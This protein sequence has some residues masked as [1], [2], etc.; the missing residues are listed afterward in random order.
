[1]LTN[2]NELLINSKLGLVENQQATNMNPGVFNFVGSS[3]KPKD[4]SEGTI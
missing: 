4:H 1:M 3:F 2:P